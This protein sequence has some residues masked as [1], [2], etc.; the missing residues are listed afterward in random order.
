MCRF[1][2]IC[3]LAVFLLA[4]S[5]C[6]AEES[7]DFKVHLTHGPGGPE[8]KPNAFAGERIFMK[9]ELPKGFSS[10]DRIDLLC[11][12][13]FVSQTDRTRFTRSP[14][15]FPIQ[16]F[17]TRNAPSFFTFVVSVPPE[18]EK[19]KYDLVLSILDRN[20]TVL[21]RGKRTIDLYSS[22]CFGVRDLIF[23]R[24]TP[25]QGRW[26]P[27]SNVFAVGEA[28]RITFA[29]GGLSPNANGEFDAVINIYLVDPEGV[30]VE[31]MEP[32]FLKS[33]PE[34][35]RSAELG[36]PWYYYD[37]RLTQPGNFVIK[38]EVEDLNAQKKEFHELPLYVFDPNQY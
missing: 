7:P 9:L 1:A 36:L 38:F 21:G 17:A 11:E 26:G 23:M 31:M 6:Y 22:S 24:G 34:A 20:G 15:P 5:V 28:A 32:S 14:M 16:G 3:V 19:G 30:S 12:A 8:R 18:F 13:L 37:F 4:S 2:I 25:S 35:F 10:N 29:M 33:K 27:G